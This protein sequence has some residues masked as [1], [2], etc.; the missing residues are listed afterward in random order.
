[1]EEV[2]GGVEAGPQYRKHSG[3]AQWHND[4]NAAIDAMACGIAS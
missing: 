3:S 1:M 4:N 2:G